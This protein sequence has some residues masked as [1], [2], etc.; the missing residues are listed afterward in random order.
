MSTYTL[1]ICKALN[2]GLT[3]NRNKAP[4]TFVKITIGDKSYETPVVKNSQNPVWDYLFFNILDDSKTDD[5]T[6]LSIKVMSKFYLQEK[7]MGM[8][9]ILFS[10][11]KKKVSEPQ[12]VILNLKN[13]HNELLLDCFL[14]III[15]QQSNHDA[16][17]AAISEIKPG[18]EKLTK[19][20]GIAK[21][22]GAGGSIADASNDSKDIAGTLG[23]IASKLNTLTSI[24]DKAAEV[25]PYV[26]LA[27][28]I[29]SSVQKA[30]SSQVERDHNIQELAETIETFFGFV[31]SLPD[32]KNKIMELKKIT[33]AVMQQTLEC[34]LFIQEYCKCGFAGRLVNQTFSNTGT[35]IKEFQANFNQLQR[36]FTTGIVTNIAIVSFRISEK[37]DKLDLHTQLNPVSGGSSQ[38]LHNPCLPGTRQKILQL[39]GQWAYAPSFEQSKQNVLWLCAQAGFGKSTLANTI[40]HQCSALHRL[41]IYHC[42]ERGKDSDLKYFI[43]TIAY[44]LRTFCPPFGVKLAKILERNPSVFDLS[45]NEHFNTLV[46]APLQ[47]IETSTSQ[48]GPVL[49][50]LDALDE[51]QSAQELAELLGSGFKQLPFFV[52][53][54]VTSRPEI[55]IKE[56]LEEKTHIYKPDLEEMSDSDDITAYLRH[57]FNVIQTRPRHKHLNLNHDWPGSEKINALLNQSSGLFIWCSTVMKFI[58]RT[59]AVVEN[60][61]IVLDKTKANTDHFSNLFTLYDVALQESGGTN[62]TDKGFSQNF[63]R[64][65]AIIIL[66]KEPFTLDSMA[67]FLGFQ[68]TM[69]VKGILQYF[70]CLLDYDEDNKPVRILHQS[71]ADYLLY[72]QTSKHPWYIQKEPEHL[73]LSKR[74]LEIMNTE[75][76]F[77]IS[78]FPSSHKFNDEVKDFIHNKIAKHLHYSCCSYMFHVKNANAGG[79]RA[80]Q[81]LIEKFLKT[82]F[83]FWLEVLSVSNCF[84]MATLSLQELMAL[85][86][87]TEISKFVED[88]IH[89]VT[90]FAPPISES[91]PHIYLSA[92]KAA[93]IHSLIAQEFSNQYPRTIGI[94]E[95]RSKGWPAAVNIFQAHGLTLSVAFSPN[96]QKIVS[97][98]GDKTIRVW[99]SNTGKQLGDSLQGHEDLVRSVAFSP[100]GQ[101]IVSGS[102][103]KTIRVWDSNTGKQLGDPLQGHEDWVHSVAFS[104]DG[105]KI[106]SGSGDKTIRVWDSNTG[107]QLGDPLQGHE[108]LVHSVAFSPDDQKIVSGSD[109]KTIRVWDSNTGK[110]L[111]DPLQ[112][113][114]DWVHSV[115]FS[116]DGQKLVSGSGDTTIRVWDS[117]TGKQLGD[118]LQG[119]EGWV[120]S[121][122]FSPDGQKIVSGSDDKTI[123]VWDSNTGKQLGDPLQGHEDWVRLVAFSPDGQK[124]V[125]GSD[126]KTIRVWDSNT[127]KQLGDS[128]QGHEDWVHSVAFSPDGQKIVSGSGDKTIRVWDSNTGKQLGDPL[129]GHEDLVHSV[130]FSPDGQKIVSG[131]NDTTIRVWDSNTG[132]QLGDPL[133]GHEDLVHS[134]AFSP[135]GQKIV[136]GSDDKTIRVWDSNTGKQ[137]GDPLQGHEDWVHS[138]AFSPDGQKIVSGSR[139][140]TIRVW[141]S[142]TGKQLGDP[143]QGHEDLFH[144]V[145]FSPDGQKIVSG[146]VDKTISIW[147]TIT[148]ISV[149]P[150]SPDILSSIPMPCHQNG[151]II[152][153]HHELLYW[154]PP[155]NHPGLYHSSTPNILVISTKRTCVSLENFVHG[156]HWAEC[157]LGTW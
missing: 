41:V 78:Q 52:R 95:G 99:D 40:A 80:V 19:H 91:A 35:R 44:R 31:D 128:L 125:S 112:G 6:S 113:H 28:T 124:I 71:F 25:H 42:F 22:V 132:K 50:V 77:N 150:D 133:Q 151:W 79:N 56:Y 59:D 107:K 9:T 33:T 75:L 86:K 26:K 129:Q 109:D 51:C 14:H 49:I 70:G 13:K 8:V 131:S 88:G 23:S 74:C 121:V 24:I 4:N 139:D 38:D 16:A 93:P 90:A 114:E 72:E 53:I 135:D 55:P 5:S 157:Y 29:A 140:K 46:L 43:R 103:D 142:N 92:L 76:K 102:D 85:V 117:N 47:E 119:H 2:L 87:Q 141:H 10:D 147:D 122:A 1:Q 15:V 120:H 101:K 69:Q 104:P 100:D 21:I 18:V 32:N 153:S 66:A 143:L 96:G 20:E 127:G 146:S 83:L 7:V 62:W 58:C 115:A 155:H 149:S 65:L 130:A 116:P 82:K 156:D 89:F 57:E 111:G 12:P 84:Y 145:A 60:L 152:G 30:V 67:R 108:D 94:V 39:I 137:L 81:E 148:K 123:R 73:Y 138:V 64:I 97:G 110:Q 126:D 98:S 17:S 34:M 54:L 36:S 105:Q 11:L 45:L 61:G 27:W 106:V 68:S 3:K 144:S 118:P 154:L 63:Q 37:L 48:E 136:S 134:V